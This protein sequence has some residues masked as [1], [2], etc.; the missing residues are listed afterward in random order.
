MRYTQDELFAYALRW[1]GLLTDDG[2]DQLEDE[3]DAKLAAGEEN[4]SLVEL[5]QQRGF[6][7]PEVRVELRGWFPLIEARIDGEQLEGRLEAL[8]ASEAHVDAAFDEQFDIFVETG[9]VLSLPAV[10]QRNGGLTAE[11]AAE[12]E[13]WL[14]AAHDSSSARQEQVLPPGQDPDETAVAGPTV[15][16]R[17]RE[18]DPDETRPGSPEVRSE[19]ALEEAGP[20]STPPAEL[21]VPD[22]VELDEPPEVE[23]SED[24]LDL[25]AQ[26]QALNVEGP[27]QPLRDRGVSLGEKYE[28]YREL[29]RGPATVTYL[30]VQ[31]GLDRLVAVKVLVSELAGNASVSREFQSRATR[32]AR[33]A[34]P[35]LTQIYE[36]GMHK[37]R[38]FLARE[39]VD[40]RTLAQLHKRKGKLPPGLVLEWLRTLVEALQTAAE[41]GLSHGDLSLGQIYLVPAD[42]TIKLTGLGLAAAFT[43][44]GKKYRGQALTSPHFCAPERLDGSEG[45]P[46]ADQYSLGVCA[47]TLLSGSYPVGGKKRAE[48]LEGHRKG[49]FAPL[50][51]VLGTQ[52]PPALNALVMR[53]L[54]REPSQRFENYEALL[55]ALDAASQQ[56]VAPSPPVVAAPPPVVPGGAAAEGAAPQQKGP[57]RRR[58]ARRVGGGSGGGARRGRRPRLPRGPSPQ[59]EAPPPHPAPP[60]PHPA[61]PHPA[62]QQGPP[63]PAPPPHPEPPPHPAPPPP[64]HPAPPQQPPAQRPEAPR[65]RRRR[66]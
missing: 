3:L 49:N 30:G 41:Q 55:E 57:K 34:H 54:A 4:V 43:P 38:P 18:A 23:E 7:S 19:P 5:A 40:G 44:P 10:L 50:S 62:P 33:V 20:Y 24:P 61:P 51:T 16:Q 42:K 36:V 21:P 13:R 46:L 11:Q 15:Q 25:T 60:P 22:L 64:P 37:N 47:Y 17:P 1:R 58:S 56:V 63:H 27:P 26:L 66:R 35:A 65:R 28:L 2:L 59:Q 39:Y 29:G 9:E 8:G 12:L 14:A 45:S 31:R 48:V 53:L 52:V 6:V 32:T